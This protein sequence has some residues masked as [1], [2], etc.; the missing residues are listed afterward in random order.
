MYI[1]IEVYDHGFPELPKR[2]AG[3]GLNHGGGPGR[4]CPSCLPRPEASCQQGKLARRAASNGDF[5]T[6]SPSGA[7]WSSAAFPPTRRFVCIELRK[8]EKLKVAR[9]CGGGHT[10]VRGWPCLP[11]NQ[12]SW[13]GSS[14]SRIRGKAGEEGGHEERGTQRG[15]GLQGARYKEM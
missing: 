3:M 5:G 10:E 12:L 8:W 6:G 14:L 13:G 15:G 11:P 2:E 1:C 7:A 4:D 9:P